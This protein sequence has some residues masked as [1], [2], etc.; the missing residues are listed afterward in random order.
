MMQTVLS[1]SFSRFLNELRLGKLSET[2]VVHSNA[3]HDRP[4]FLV[5][6]ESANAQGPRV[7]MASRLVVEMFRRFSAAGVPSSISI[8]W[9]TDGYGPEEGAAINE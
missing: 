4:R 8:F 5:N 7:W 2:V 6:H 1:F 9:T 3:P